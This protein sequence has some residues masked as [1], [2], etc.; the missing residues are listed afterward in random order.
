[1]SSFTPCLAMILLTVLTNIS[2]AQNASCPLYINI[3]EPWRNVGFCSTTC[4]KSDSK[5]TEGWY[6]F[7][8]ISGDQVVTSCANTLN[9]TDG[10]VTNLLVCNASTTDFYTCS[11]GFTVFYLRPSKGIYATRHSYC[12]N[13]SCGPNAFCGTV[14]GSCVCKPGFT[15]S[16]DDNT[17]G[18]SVLTMPKDCQETA[19]C[20]ENF[21]NNLDQLLN[22]SGP[23]EQKTVELYLVSVM[24]VT[25]VIENFNDSLLISLGNKVLAVTER[26]VSSLVTPT[27]T[28]NTTSINLSDLEARVFSVG[29]MTSLTEIPPLVTSNS[30]LSIDLIGI[31]KKN[32]GSAA[33]VFV[34]Y[35]NMANILKPSFFSLMSN[36]NK[37]MM[38]TVVSAT[39]PMTS[40]K[41]LTKPVQFAFKYTET[42]GQSANLFCVY[43]KETEWVKDGCTVKD[44]NSTHTVCSCTHLSTFALIM[45]TDPDKGDDDEIIELINTVG[46]SVGLLFLFLTILTLAV[47]Q[48]GPKVTNVAL[49]NLSISL[50]FAHLVFLLT[51]QYQENVK[52]SQFSQLCEVLAGVTHFLFL[53]AFVW[54]F[55]EAVLLY[56]CV[57]NLS[58]ISSKQVDVLNW[59]CMIVI[60][61]IIPLVLVGVTSGLYPDAYSIDHCW[62]KGGVIWAFLGPVCGIIAINFLLSCVIIAILHCSLSSLDKSV[63]HLKHTR[64]LVL[65]TLLQFV[66]LGCPWALGFFTEQNNMIKI[67]FLFLNSQQGTF[68]FIVH[69]VLNQEIRHQYRKW[70]DDLYHCSKYKAMSEDHNRA[71]HSHAN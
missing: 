65:K 23:L 56:I 18:C 42:L 51:Q 62:L 70:W 22:N 66:I 5:L 69:C 40:S 13:S 14:Y 10:T 57:K 61:Y 33:V 68:I 27:E 26:L 49:L 32:N 15:M 34:S 38:S 25:S 36:T 41:S 8:G 58:R 6:R 47:C 59:K 29:K 55:T 30:S 1:M 35:S 21:L 31:S 64:T 48:R 37:T 11:K 2:T 46:V 63:S 4:N 9:N 71:S 45:Q 19:A 43:W 44:K 67:I 39:L 3:S 60:G 28:Q 50:F 24:N 20:A 12:S 7:I 53:S 52:Q 54:M 16:T 17:Y